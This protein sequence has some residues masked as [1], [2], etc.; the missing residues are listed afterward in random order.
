MTVLDYVTLSHAISQLVAQ[1]ATEGASS[2]GDPTLEDRLG[3]VLNSSTMGVSRKQMEQPSYFL[4]K[5]S[6]INP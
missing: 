1:S 6:V 3:L 5:W 4:Q 2:A